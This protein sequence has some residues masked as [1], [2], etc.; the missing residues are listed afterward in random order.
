MR[1]WLP[2]HNEIAVD[3][4]TMSAA[5]L[6]YNQADYTTQYPAPRECGLYADSPALAQ[7]W[8]KKNG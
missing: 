5:H 8:K 3:S 1:G 2:H 6:L 4:D 7:E